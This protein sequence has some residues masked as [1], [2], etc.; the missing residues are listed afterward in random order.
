MVESE[1]VEICGWEKENK[2]YEMKIFKTYTGNAMLNNALMTIE[3]LGN[4]KNVSEITPDILLQLYKEKGLLKLNKRLKSYTMLFTKNGPLHNDKANGDKTYE[5]L[6]KTIISSFENEGDKRCEISGLKFNSSFNIIFEKALKSIGIAEKEIKKKDTKL[7]RTWFPLIGGLGSDAQALPQAKFTIQIHPICI[8]IMQFLPLSS[9]LYKGGILLIDSSNFEFAKTFVAENQKELE[10]RIQATKSTDSV[11]NIKDF[12]KGNYLLKALKILESK[13]DFEEAYSDLNL[14]SFSNSGTGASCE[15]E[16]IPN[17]LIQKLIHLKR[18]PEIRQELL[19]IL[20]INQRGYSFLNSFEDNA[21]W[22]LLYPNVF[23]SGKKKVEYTGVSVPFLEAY[24]KETGNNKKTEYAKYIAYLV[25]KYKSKSFE[26]YLSDSSAWNE[27]D[28]RI[29]LYTVLVEA[30]KN[31]EWSLDNHLQIIDDTDQLP[32][33]NTFYKIQKLVHFY[34]Q[35]KVYTDKLPAYPNMATNVKNVCEWLIALI[36]K[37]ENNTRLIKD[38]TS[39]QNYTSVGFGGLLLRN[40]ELLSVDL[41]TIVKALYN[42]NFILARAGLNELLRIFFNQS[43]QAIFEIAK[44]KLSPNLKLD[45]AIEKWFD[46]FEKFA[47]DY[48]AYYFNKYESKGKILKLVQGIS[49]ENSPF[50]YW[51][52]EAIEKTND[53]L[54]LKHV[55]TPGTWSDVI[56]YSPQGEFSLSFAKFAIKFSMLKNH[57]L[58]F[59]QQIHN[60]IS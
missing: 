53:F 32:I 60:L 26:K 51:F 59:N 34:Y 17:S 7:S 43:K 57:Q 55:N 21:E 58:S 38:L 36:Q 20:N 10:K 9:L 33:K 31:G 54:N 40:Y 18:N 6:F 56:L 52:R 45:I 27:K 46:D 42:V 22:G 30:T 37:D 3:S 24:F 14:W 11:E 28:Y 12:S 48:Q 19:D 29:D 5:A 35:N 13:E 8:A 2:K 41:I 15:I 47:N 25:D 39:A 1:G 50:L 16:R 49:L 4:L 23:G 44:L